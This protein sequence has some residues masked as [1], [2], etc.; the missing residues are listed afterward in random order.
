MRRS[1]HLS[2]VAWLLAALLA[3][4]AVEGERPDPGE[5]AG[6]DPALDGPDGPGDGSDDGTD[7]ASGGKDDSALTLPLRFLPG[8]LVVPSAAIQH[9]VRKVF[10]SAAA[11]EAALGIPNPGIDFSREW[12]VFYTPG[13]ARPDLLP[14][15]WARIDTVRVSSTGLT[16]MVTTSLEQNGACAARRSRPFLLV[17]VPRP[18]TPP[19]YTRFY[20]ADRT[21][22]CPGGVTYHD[23]VPFTPAEEAAALRAA[24]LATPGELHA[25][26]ITGAQASIVTGGRTWSRLAAV[27]GT[28]GIGSATMTKLRALGASF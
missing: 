21:R 25:A 15:F 28:A 23:G 26:G 1:R 6:A 11:L 12:A 18:E 17:A 8:E 4:C 20:R 10:R 24:N 16:I 22:A 7:G 13:M 2:L 27:A 9:E 14:G 3:G 5:V 19:P